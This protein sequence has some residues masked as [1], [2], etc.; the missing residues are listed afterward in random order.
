M[1]LIRT[2]INYLLKS[3]T[4]TKVII[5]KET[6][7]VFEEV[8]KEAKK[9]VSSWGGEFYFAYIPEY[10]RFAE[11]PSAQGPRYENEVFSILDKLNIKVINV[12]E[13]V[14][15]KQRPKGVFPFW[16]FWSL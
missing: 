6:L 16:A 13:V 4:Q 1:R 15:K 5:T 10:N 2:H 8:L 12:L 3:K 11:I 7:S 14:K 9:T